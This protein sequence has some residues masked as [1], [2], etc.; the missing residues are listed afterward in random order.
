MQFFLFAARAAFAHLGEAMNQE[1]DAIDAKIEQFLN[2]DLFAVAGAST[3]RNKYGNKVLRTYV[4]DGRKVHP[5]NPK[6]EEVEGLRAFPDVD[7]LPE[8]VAALSI[9]TP[10]VVTRA[11]VRAALK[12]GIKEIW[13]QPGAED[14]VA[15][16][17]AEAAGANVIHGGACLLVVLGF[18]G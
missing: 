3:D 1:L 2:C 14:E 12:R 13:M 7:S 10:P 17:E 8:G 15:I 16:A 9:I 5:I 6:A 18:H 11:V 4:N